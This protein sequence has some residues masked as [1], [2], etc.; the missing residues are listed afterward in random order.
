M[1]SREE[2]LKKLEENKNKPGFK[3]SPVSI[4]TKS[5]PVTINLHGPKEFI[6]VMEKKV[7]TVGNA[8]YNKKMFSV[9]A[10]S[11]IPIYIFSLLSR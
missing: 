10:K 5:G 2:K 6:S 4:S 7:T 3:H 11:K 1:A 9:L 8:S